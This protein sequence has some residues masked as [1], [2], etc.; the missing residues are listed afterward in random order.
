M[1]TFYEE[2][3][4][5]QPHDWEVSLYPHQL[6]SIHKMEQIENERCIEKSENISIYTKLG[7]LADI[8]GYGKTLSILGLISRNRTG[9]E[10]Q[11]YREFD[12]QGNRDIYIEKVS[13]RKPIESNLLIVPSAL[14]DHWKTECLKTNIHPLIIDSKKQCEEINVEEHSVVICPPAIYPTLMAVNSTV[15]WK[16]IIFDEPQTLGNIG[17]SQFPA[18]FVWLVTATP[19]EI[20]KKLKRSIFGNIIPDNM[21]VFASILVKN[22]DEFVRQSFSMPSVNHIWYKCFHPS[23]YILRG[24][25]PEH[26][27]EMIEAGNIK[28]AL[29]S[30]GCNRKD[31]KVLYEVVQEK[32]QKRIN[33]LKA[34]LEL[35]ESSSEREKYSKKIE[36]Q[37][38]K[39]EEI[40]SRVQ[41]CLSSDCCIC[42]E[43]MN[44]PIMMMCCQNIIC[45]SCQL[46]WTSSNSTCPFCRQ[47]LTFKN[48]TIIEKIDSGKKIL[49]RSQIVM[50]ILEKCYENNG[51][52]IIY[53]NHDESFFTLKEIFNER[54]W[55]WNDMKGKREAKEKSLSAFRE[56]DTRIL[57]LNSQVNSSGFNL[58]ETTDIV[59]YHQVPDSIELQVLG[60][61]L[62][63]G[64]E[65]TLNVHHIE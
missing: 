44:D 54:G 57:L 16:R 25:I 24:H 27:Q 53:S 4:I 3:S 47:N 13:Y 14:I 61:A 45:G 9:W 7:I 28:G 46:R 37:L 40:K 21:E 17:Y 2:K 42:H 55:N 5:T 1:N 22:V 39:M 10:D 49:T 12:Y 58:P 11:I 43:K 31:E 41:E 18:N 56:G 60:R 38:V 29:W 62:R 51:R 50:E 34:H 23:S 15:A 64:R 59:F 35:A 20:M 63:I 52:I 32:C 65:N 19:L 8:T 6:L 33:L 48:L 30:L 36:K 26:T